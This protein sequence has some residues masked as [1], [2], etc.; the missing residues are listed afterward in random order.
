MDTVDV[1]TQTTK[2]MLSIYKNYDHLRF[3][4]YIQPQF[5]LTQTKGIKSFEGGDFAARV[6]NRFMIRRSQ[7]RVNYVHFNKDDKLGVQFVFQIDTNERSFT[8]RD[9]WGRIFENKFNLFSF[10]T[11]LIAKPFGYEVNLSSS[12]RESPRKRK[13]EPT[14]NEG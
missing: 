1:I 10:T 5:L 7:V 14:T 8:V 2:I 6:S 11:G 3:S 9:V 12:D 13:N 4:G